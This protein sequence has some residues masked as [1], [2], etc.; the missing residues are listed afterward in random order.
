MDFFNTIACC[1]SVRK[2][3]DTINIDPDQYESVWSRVR[4]CVSFHHDILS[5]HPSPSLTLTLTVKRECVPCVLS[6]MGSRWGAYS[7]HSIAM[8]C[9]YSVVYLT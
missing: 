3:G 8:E 2:P 7:I 5:C 1:A 9:M 4:L 6:L